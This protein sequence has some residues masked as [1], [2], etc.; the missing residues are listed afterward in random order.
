MKIYFYLV[1][2]NGDLGR[3]ITYWE[4]AIVVPRIGEAFFY[5]DWYRVKDIL[6]EPGEIVTI[7]L[8]PDYDIGAQNK[9]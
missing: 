4:N 8:V 7:K 1:K 9:D 6:W 2:K 3:R 5:Q